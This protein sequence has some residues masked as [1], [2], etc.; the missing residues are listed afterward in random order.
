MSHAKHATLPSAPPLMCATAVCP[1]EARILVRRNRTERR[2]GLLNP[3]HVPYGAWLNLCHS[4][5]ERKVHQESVDY[6]ALMG[7]HTPQEQRA[8]CL[9]QIKRSADMLR[10]EPTLREPGQDES[11]V[12]A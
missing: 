2:V 11:E 7:L 8:W 1:Y 3:V 10:P 5:D 12:S 4:C 6:C 9:A